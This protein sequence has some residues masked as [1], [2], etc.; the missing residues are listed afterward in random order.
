MAQFKIE[1]NSSARFRY[2]FRGS[3]AVR[4]GRWDAWASLL[5]DNILGYTVPTTFVCRYPR[6]AA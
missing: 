4:L 1:C 3:H 6:T 2:G 5:L